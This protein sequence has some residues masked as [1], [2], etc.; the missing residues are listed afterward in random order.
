MC[1]EFPANRA[2]SR[3]LLAPR[4]SLSIG[5]PCRIIFSSGAMRR[6]NEAMNSPQ[7]GL[8]SRN[9]SHNKKK[10]ASVLANP[11]HDLSTLVYTLA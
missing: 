1:M 6:C 10:Q 7:P 2:S 4:S 9:D 11:S 8:G 3:A 5:N